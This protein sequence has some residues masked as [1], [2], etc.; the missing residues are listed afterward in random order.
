MYKKIHNNNMVKKTVD[1]TINLSSLMPLILNMS[2]FCPNRQWLKIIIMRD[3]YYVYFG[4]MREEST[5]TT[6]GRHRQGV[7]S[8]LAGLTYSLSLV[9]LFSS[10]IMCKI[11]KTYCWLL[12]EKCDERAT[13]WQLLSNNMLWYDIDDFSSSF[14]RRL[15]AHSTGNWMRW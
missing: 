10:V 9:R 3:V 2:S 4:G 12:C 13:N 6:K 7:G 8:Y 15:Y 11:C 5:V 14:E 1:I